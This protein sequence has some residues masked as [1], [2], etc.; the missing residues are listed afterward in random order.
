MFLK[1]LCITSE[2]SMLNSNV[3]ITQKG[4]DVICRDPSLKEYYVRFINGVLWTLFWVKMRCSNWLLFT[5]DAVWAFRQRENTKKIVRIKLFSQKGLKGSVVNRTL[6][7]RQPWSLSI[8]KLHLLIHKF[9]CS[10]SYSFS[11]QLI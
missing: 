4:V 7:I 3:K 11:S 6:Q 2:I 10:F 5:R 9:Y 8:T 1:S